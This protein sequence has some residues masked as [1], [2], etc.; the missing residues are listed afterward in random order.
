[1]VLVYKSKLPSRVVQWEWFLLVAAKRSEILVKTSSHS[2]SE[3]KDI[4]EKIK[5]LDSQVWNFKEDRMQKKRK[6][7][8]P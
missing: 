4:K 2:E 7:T 1:M 8:Q 6:Y 5:T 3:Q